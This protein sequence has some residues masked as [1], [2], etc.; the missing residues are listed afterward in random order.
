MVGILGVVALL[1]VA[2]AGASPTP[3][4]APPTPTPAATRTNAEI[5]A[6]L[7]DSVDVVFC[8]EAPKPSW[9]SQ[10][11][12]NGK[13]YAIEVDGTTVFVGSK[14]PNTKAGKKAALA[15]C[16]DLAPLHF[17]DDAKDLGVAHFHV[18]DASGEQILAE[19]N[20]PGY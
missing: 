7:S 5:A 6:I 8:A 19:C 17:D 10:I 4:S 3:V 2:C 16:K 11:R 14:L 1:L 13:L 9:C 15:M 12:K 20:I 18:F